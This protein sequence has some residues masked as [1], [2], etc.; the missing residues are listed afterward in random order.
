MGRK[1]IELKDRKCKSCGKGAEEVEFYQRKGGSYKS[2][3]K[4]CWRVYTRD[5]A[6]KRWALKDSEW[7]RSKRNAKFK[8]K[9]GITL[10]DY[11]QML[12]QQSGVCAI[13]AQTESRKTESGRDRWLAVDHNHATGKVRALLCGACNTSIGAMKEDPARLRKAAE[14]LESQ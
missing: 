12:K 13:C 1:R 3:C 8:E 14:Y 5:Y 11:E 6:R 4:G 9:F 10:D 2:V 7:V